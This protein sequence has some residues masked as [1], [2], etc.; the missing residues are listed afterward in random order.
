MKF[1]TKRYER[2]REK[3][4]MT[5]T[6]IGRMALIFFTWFSFLSKILIEIPDCLPQRR[7]TRLD[8]RVSITVQGELIC[9]GECRE[10]RVR[11]R[12][13]VSSILVVIASRRAFAA[14]CD[15]ASRVIPKSP[16]ERELS[17]AAQPPPAYNSASRFTVG[18]RAN[19]N[20]RKC[21]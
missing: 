5:R 7:Q 18:V 8:S 21:C 9:P 15:R 11:S 20:L 12:V 10:R 1:I 3:S 13:R 6:M 17:S 16:A 19:A 14:P 2:R 4:D